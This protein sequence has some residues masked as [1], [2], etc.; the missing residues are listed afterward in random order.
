MP[1]GLDSSFSLQRVYRA[2]VLPDGVYEFSLDR[3]SSLQDKLGSLLPMAKP[4][5]APKVSWTSPPFIY[6]SYTWRVKVSIGCPEAAT[7]SAAAQAQSPIIGVH[8]VCETNP[9]PV[10]AKG[11]FYIKHRTEDKYVIKK[12]MSEHEFKKNKGVGF[13]RVISLDEL[14]KLGGYNPKEDVV[15]FG[16]KITPIK[17]LQKRCWMEMEESGNQAGAG[18]LVDVTSAHSDS[19]TEPE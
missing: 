15:T 19:D 14:S 12:Q 16:V 17:G 5:K 13:G 2:D 9:Q 1:F 6:R 8:L 11:A 18:L 4:G 7:G 10:Q 3:L